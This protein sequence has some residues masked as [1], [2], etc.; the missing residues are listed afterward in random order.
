[1]TL[2]ELALGRFPLGDG[3]SGDTVF[4]HM[5]VFEIL[6]HIVH[7]PIPIPPADQYSSTFSDF[8]LRTLTRDPKLRPSPKQLLADDPYVKQSEQVSFDMVS[9]ARQYLDP[10]LN[11]HQMN[12]WSRSQQQKRQS[13]LELRRS[14]LAT[15]QKIIIALTDGLDRMSVRASR[16]LG[17]IPVSPSAETSLEDKVDFIAPP[18]SN[19]KKQ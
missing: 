18:R 12:R 5:T 8:I 14:S 11:E 9:W 13:A 17:A 19:N 15:G 10:N 7:D 3:M 2:L 6:T 4:L 1:M 16:N